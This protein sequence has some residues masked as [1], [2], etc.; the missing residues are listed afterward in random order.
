MELPAF[1]S[2]FVIGS[3]IIVILFPKYRLRGVWLVLT[4]SLG[5]GLGLGITSSTIFLWLALIGPPD[6]YYFAAELSLAVILSLFAFYH[7]HYSEI[8]RRQINLYSI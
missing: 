3:S 6:S 1:I 2:P 8:P 7:V 4:I 5:A